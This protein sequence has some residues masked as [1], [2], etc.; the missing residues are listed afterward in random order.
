METSIMH[1]TQ[2]IVVLWDLQNTPCKK[3]NY[4]IAALLNYLKKRG[5]I[6]YAAVFNDFKSSD[7]PVLKQLENADFEIYLVA[8]L[9][10][11]W[12]LYNGGTF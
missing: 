10:S 11:Q 2:K 5:S 4:P 6:E 12:I 1:H 7:D 3:R 8:L 9:S